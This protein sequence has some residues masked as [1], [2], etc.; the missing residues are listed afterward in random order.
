M[1]N[2]FTTCLIVFGTLFSAT[3]QVEESSIIIDTYYGFPNLY[4]S[5]LRT[6]YDSETND[7]FKI[8]GYGPVGVRGEYMFHDKMGVG[9]DF[10][11]NSSKVS[12]N[13]AGVSPTTGAAAVYTDEISTTKIG[14]MATFS[15]H[16]ISTDRVD[17]FG[18]AGAGFKNRSWKYSSTNPDNL[19]LSL[20]GNLLPIAGRIG[21][22]TR[23]FFTDNLAANIGLGF[24]QG[25][26]V[27]AGLSLAL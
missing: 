22:G 19:D 18:V 9:I 12:Y 10:M 15:Y 3:S 8:T 27:N 21:V 25:G 20:S 11:I 2:L 26:I 5:V 7:D 23:I 17:F 4:A 13:Y 14:V 16:F 1:K 24:G 6:G